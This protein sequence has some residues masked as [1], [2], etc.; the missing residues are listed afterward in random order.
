VPCP[1]RE[2][3][4]RRF[5]G[6]GEWDLNE[7]G[8][9]LTEAKSMKMNSMLLDSTHPLMIREGVAD[10]NDFENKYGA[11][12][13]IPSDLKDVGLKNMMGRV[14]GEGLPDQAYEL[15]N[16]IKGQMQ[17]RVGAFSTQSD[18]PDIAAMGTATGIAAITEQTIGRRGPQLQ[19]YA[20]MEVD[21]AY[22]KLELRQKYWC[23]KM[24]S[25]VATDLG[26]DAVKWFMECN[27]R[28]DINISVVPD[29][30]M[31][32]S[33]AKKQAGLQSMLGLV[34]EIMMAKGDPKMLDDVVRQANDIF[35]T[36]FDFN[37]Y[38]K[39]SVE[40][41][42]KARHLTRCRQV[43]RAAV[44]G[45][46]LRRRRA[47]R[48]EAIAL[49]YIQTAEMLKIAHKPADA[50]DIF[51]E[52]P[53]DVMFDNH[54]EFIEAYT[55]WLKTAEGR[56]ASAFIRLLRSHARGVSHSGRRL[57]DAQREPIFEGSAKGRSRRSDRR[58]Q[59]HAENQPQEPPPAPN[60]QQPVEPPKMAEAD[61]LA[62]EQ[63]HE[64]ELKQMDIDAAPPAPI[65]EKPAVN[66]VQ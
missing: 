27:I 41:Q 46:P 18:A 24:Y 37:D 9:Q 29:S 49:A 5:H 32:Q 42:L 54:T 65:G 48:D 14:P 26:D 56:A 1:R 40:G 22:Q 4:R 20:Q 25:T 50:Q 33:D 31:P 11:I 13:T 30:W 59:G 19:L 66:R 28:Q 16:E 3:Y 44:R 63:A 60:P 45:V 7:L 64:K 62:S 17:Q 57:P 34:G 51:A 43:R 23:K 39:D 38:E 8:D 36:G 15:G 10:A 53:I 61:S 52:L 47:V 6:Q 35:G 21:Q 55:D 12:V 2:R 58:R